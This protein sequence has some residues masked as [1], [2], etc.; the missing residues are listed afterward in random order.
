[1]KKFIPALDDDTL[2]T[3]T[4]LESVGFEFSSPGQGAKLTNELGYNLTNE[5]GYNLMTNWV[6]FDADRQWYFG[7]EYGEPKL[8]GEVMLV[9]DIK[10]R[11]D[12]RLLLIALHIDIP[13]PPP[14][15]QEPPRDQHRDG[16]APKYKPDDKDD[17]DYAREL[18]G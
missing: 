2:I 1:M 15:P 16:P 7:T 6:R 3:H 4:W 17:I 10:T 13:A 8:D 14:P 18:A 11:G 5:L 9:S 12:V